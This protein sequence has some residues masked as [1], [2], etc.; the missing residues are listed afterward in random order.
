MKGKA[1]LIVILI[2]F[3]CIDPVTLKVGEGSGALVVDGLV[4]NLLGPYSITLSR[5]QTF[6]NT[7]TPP[8]FLVPE[9]NAQVSIVENHINTFPLTENSPGVYVT[10]DGFTAQV[11]YTYRVDIITS[12]GNHYAS[13]DEVMPVTT[14]INDL[15]FKYVVYEN[16]IKNAS[17]K[18]VKVN[19]YGFSVSAKVQDPVELGNFYRWRIRGIFEFFSITDNPEIHQ[20]WAPKDR[21]ET[22][23]LVKAD[24]Y[25]NGQSFEE[26]IAIVPYD[27]ATYYLAII[28]QHAITRSSFLFWN[29]IK[30]QQVST[31][32][33]FDPIPSSIKGNIFNVNN[34]DETVIGFFGAS[35]VTERKVLINRFKESGNVSPTPNIL[36]LPGDCRT[37]IPRATNIKPEGFP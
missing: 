6:D 7:R 37:H 9:T 2:T 13:V 32:S 31:G 25:I 22:G 29:A 10:A 33:I 21:L 20:C 18:F 15:P 16:L 30:D 12:D 36:P 34:S 28:Q 19:S 27:R 5:S 24:A 17:G 8:V 14:L 1:F 26:P 35:A 23:V 4:T 11:G 3:S